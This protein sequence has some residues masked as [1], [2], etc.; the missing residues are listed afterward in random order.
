[1]Y[2]TGLDEPGAILVLIPQSDQKGPGEILFLPPRNLVREKWTG[3]KV[4]PDDPGVAGKLGFESV[5]S[6]RAFQTELMKL[7][8]AFN[9]FNTVASS[10]ALKTLAPF[11]EFRDATR[12]IAR[13]RMVKGETEIRLLEKAVACSLD[14]HRAAYQAAKPGVFEYEIGA[15]M[16]YTFQR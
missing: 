14:A 10:D 4:G 3:I 8:P 11:A 13:L 12:S 15:L 9:S 1:Y 2:L 7:L 6:T 16:Q 5:M